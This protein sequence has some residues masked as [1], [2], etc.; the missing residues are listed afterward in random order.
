MKTAAIVIKGTHCNACKML[1]EDVSCE[2]AGI[3]SCK[4]DFATGKTEIGYDGNVDW[5]KFKI[6]VES[7]GDYKVEM[8]T[9]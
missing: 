3:N 7:L 8:I 2:I 9:V 5:N 6:E 4:V 1:I